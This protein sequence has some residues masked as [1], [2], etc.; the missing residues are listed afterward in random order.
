L[1]IKAY[2]VNEDR[3]PYGAQV[4]EVLSGIRPLRLL[5]SR[6]V[7][8][9][10]EKV[11]EGEAAAAII[12]PADFSAKIDANQPAR[13][14]LVKD[15]T[16]QAEARAVA[17]I[18][19]EVLTE[20]SVRAEIEYGIRAVYEKTGALEGAAPEVARAAQ[21]QTMGAFWTAVQ[22]I[23]QNPAIADQRED[24]A[25]EK[26]QVPVSGLA[27]AACVPLF[28]TMFAFFLVGFMAE[29]ILG[30]REAGSFRRLLAAPIQR[31]TV[32]AAR[33]WPLSGWW[34]CKCCCCLG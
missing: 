1:V 30:E 8:R 3:G 23:R 5:R 24:L 21:A 25:G 32:V 12:I 22:E 10:D 14:Q 28:A 15:P 9:A 27:F 31:G 34:S 19:N 16:H 4:E 18:L 26:K 13:I 6:T 2:V 11:A 33:C 17:G 29:S 20:L 7:D